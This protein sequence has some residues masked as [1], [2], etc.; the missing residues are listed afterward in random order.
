[1]NLYTG[2]IL[3]VNLSTNKVEFEDLNQDWAGQYIGGKGLGFRYLLEEIDPKIDSLSEDNK[4][5]FFTGPFAGT[6]VPTSS[7]LAVITKSPA[8]GAILDSYV[9]GSIAAE[10]KYAGIDAVIIEG[11]SKSPVY[12][13][14]NDESI[15]IHDA[16]KMW[17]KGIFETESKIRRERGEDYKTLSI[18]QA[19]E[20]LIPFACITSESYR[21]AGRGGTGAIMGSKNLKAIAVRGSKGI[22]VLNLEKF[23]DL[24]LGIIFNN[25]LT[26]KNLWA[27]T[28]GTPIIVDI[29]NKLGYLP[30][31]NFQSGVFKDV[32]KLN[33]EA[34]KKVKIRDR[35]CVS[36]PLACGKF[37]RANGSK[38]EG[39][40]YETLVL[41]GGLIVE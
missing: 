11:K 35:A 13:E 18:G 15:K 9:G 31:N 28:D 14:I 7:R 12:L 37:T 26:D 10:I 19:G 38:V 36:C 25:V 32:D 6:I 39:P 4:L 23:L 20:S 27:N 29:V 30:T 33:S 5:L 21:Q 3:R 1:M 17:G 40:D 16:G 24:V 2:K 41:G 34:I 8:T 22:K